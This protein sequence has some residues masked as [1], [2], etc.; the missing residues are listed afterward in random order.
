MFVYGGA[1]L[2]L[3]V[4]TCGRWCMCVRLF[5]LVWVICGVFLCENL[6]VFACTFVRF[7]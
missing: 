5:A 1:C 2:R 3:F 6:G 7:L 4:H